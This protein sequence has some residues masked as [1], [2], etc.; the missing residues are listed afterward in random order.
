MI[1]T[2]IV[3][4]GGSVI[5][6]GK[7]DA[8]DNVVVDFKKNGRAVE[9]F[10]SGA[11]N[12]YPEADKLLWEGAIEADE[13]IIEVGTVDFEGQNI[14]I[15]GLKGSSEV[16]LREIALPLG[17]SAH[18]VDLKPI[19]AWFWVGAAVGVLGLAYVVT[20]KG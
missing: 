5:P 15:W 19:P 4:R 11:F 6:E 8:I 13:L 2:A 7:W 18:R 17:D 20:R 3:F 12:S 1:V 9:T 14:T 16:K 10:E